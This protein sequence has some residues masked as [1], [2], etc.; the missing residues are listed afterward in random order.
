[1][2]LTVSGTSVAVS[3]AAGPATALPA[4]SQADN[5]PD[6][7]MVCQAGQIDINHADDLALTTAFSIDPPVAHRIIELRPYLG[8]RDLLVVPGIGPGKLTEILASGKACATPTQLPP[9][10]DEACGDDR[11]DLQ[12]ADTD[13]LVTRLG[14]SRPAAKRLIQARPFATGRHVTPERVPGVGKGTLDSLRARSCLTPAPVKTSTTNYRWIYRSLGGHVNRG[15]FSLQ[16]PENVLTPFGAWAS[17]TDVSAPSPLSGP[18]ADFHIWGNWGNGESQRVSVTLPLDP[19]LTAGV[20]LDFDPVAV[21]FP[22]GTEPQIFAGAAADVNLGRKTLT[23]STASLSILQAT[24]L[25]KPWIIS[26]PTATPFSR[27]QML[28]QT[29]QEYA[30]VG[31]SQPECNPDVSSSELVATHGSMFDLRLATGQPFFRHCVEAASGAADWKLANNTGAAMLISPMGEPTVISV[32]PSGNLLTDLF[33][34]KKNGSGPYP[35]SVYVPPGG[36]AIVRVPQGRTAE[37]VDAAVPPAVNASAYTLRQ[38]DKVLKPDELADLYSALNDCGYSISVSQADLPAILACASTAASFVSARAKVVL[39]AVNFIIDTETYL[40]DTLRA[41]FQRELDAYLTYRYPPPP[42]PGGGGNGGVGPDGSILG[43]GQ[44]SGLLWRL[45]SG[46]TGDQRGQ[47]YLVLEEGGVAVSTL[48][49]STI[50][51]LNRRYILRDF[52]NRQTVPLP[53]TQESAYPATCD[54]SQPEIQLP[55]DA[56]NWVLR[57]S[58]GSAWFVDQ[59]SH[60]QRIETG[61]QYIACVQRHY[62]LDDAPAAMVDQFGDRSAAPRATCG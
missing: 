5:L 1:M 17:I 46:P 28:L 19:S 18:A 54:E 50:A 53:W 10:S 21:H 4:A 57:M 6:V 30:G 12:T 22:A 60:L 9:P 38:F 31:A 24:W 41:I 40:A 32:R 27:R 48:D 29:V 15:P 16:V 34:A 49:A 51:C 8:P 56:R 13:E 23:V 14:M 3:V 25:P 59:N 11:P 43:A 26:A 39:E 52:V 7:S 58:N 2:M 35:G 44:R 20:D 42:N 36:S 61:G 37:K 47:A 62:V 45:A 55:A 33:F